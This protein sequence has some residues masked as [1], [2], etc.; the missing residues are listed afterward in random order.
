MLFNGVLQLFKDEVFGQ[1]WLASDSRIL[2]GLDPGPS[3]CKAD[4]MAAAL[5]KPVT[6][7]KCFTQWSANRELHDSF[8]FDHEDEKKTL[9]YFSRC[10]LFKFFKTLA[11][12]LLALPEVLNGVKR[13]MAG[14]VTE[15]TVTFLPSTVK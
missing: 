8:F 9:A 2:A 6:N 4:V 13:Q 7:V 5:R 1:N 14:K 12:L 10:S 11:L 3:A 15:K